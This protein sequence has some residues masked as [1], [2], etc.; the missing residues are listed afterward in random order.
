MSKVYIKQYIGSPLK[1]TVSLIKH[2]VT[3]EDSDERSFFKTISSLGL[4]ISTF[5]SA[6]ITLNALKIHNV[7]GDSEEVQEQL[8]SY[9]LS[10]F[11]WN[12]LSFLGASNLIGNPV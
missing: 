6:P 2:G 8:K 7:F 9:Y 11:K 5:E 3:L 10:M 12:T 1:I 4:T